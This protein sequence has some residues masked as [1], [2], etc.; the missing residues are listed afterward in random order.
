MAVKLAE[1][2]QPNAARATERSGA[3]DQK[4]LSDL[5]RPWG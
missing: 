4:G 5:K 2:R 1:Y 3:E